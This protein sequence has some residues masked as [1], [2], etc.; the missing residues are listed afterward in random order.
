MPCKAYLSIC[1]ITMAA[2]AASLL[3]M[4]AP[5]RAGDDVWSTLKRARFGD[6][7]IEALGVTAAAVQ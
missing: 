7:V 5:V 1:A 3:V 4:P 6:R 2:L